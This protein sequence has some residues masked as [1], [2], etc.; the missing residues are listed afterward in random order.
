MPDDPVS[1]PLPHFLLLLA[2]PPPIVAARIEAAWR[3]IGRRE[4]F[5]GHTLHMTILPLWRRQA[6]EPELIEAVRAALA[7]LS[8][9]A[10]DLR[11]DR[12]TTFGPQRRRTR[13]LVLTCSQPHPQADALA[14]ECW[15][16]LTAAGLGVACHNVT[17]HV[18]LAFGRP[19]RPDPIAVPP[20]LWRVDELRLI[21][22]LQ[23][24]GRHLTLGHWQLGA[25]T[26]Q[27]TPRSHPC[28]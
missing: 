5:R 1:T 11:L 18:T 12:L 14:Q 8:F 16:L 17:A 9:P 21:D 7:P 22:S 24:Q 23:G 13:P 10:F 4:R 26:S 6:A 20:I 28:T 15:R 25:G 2:V 19:L 3:S 27:F